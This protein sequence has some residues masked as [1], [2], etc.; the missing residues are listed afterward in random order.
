MVPVNTGFVVPLEFVPAIRVTKELNVIHVF[1]TL[2][3]NMVHVEIT[4]LNVI[5]MM[6]LR[7][8]FVTNLNAEKDAILNM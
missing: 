5:A 8:C 1:Q 7:V 3:A 6:V 4:H 2:T